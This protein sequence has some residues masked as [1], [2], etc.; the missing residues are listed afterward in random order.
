MEQGGWIVTRKL[1]PQKNYFPRKLPAGKLPA[2]KLLPR[3][4]PAGKLPAGKLLPRKLPAG[5]LPA[6]KLLPRKCNYPAAL[7]C[8]LPYDLGEIRGL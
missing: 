4:L 5:K 3:K 2:G 1:L 7:K 6:G 8:F